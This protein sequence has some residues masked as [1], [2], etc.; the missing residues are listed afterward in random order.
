MAINDVI[1]KVAGQTFTGWKSVQVDRAIDALV[2]S[3]RLTLSDR[4]P[5]APD[6]WGIRAGDACEVLLGGETI[7]TA[8]IDRAAFS[9]RP[10]R[11]PIVMSGMEKTIDLTDCSAIHTPG[12]WKGRRLEQIA[13]DLTAPFGIKVKALV[14]TGAVFPAFALQQGESVFEAISRMARQRGVLPVTNVDG[15]LELIRPGQARAGFTLAYGENLEEIAFEDDYGDRFSDYILK[16]YARDGAS[17]PKAT[18]K[19]AGVTRYRPLLIVHDDDSTPGNL[20]DRAKH[21]AT[22][23]AGRGQR[24]QATVTGWRDAGGELYR[25][26]RLAA[27]RAAVVGVE[28]ERLIHAVSYRADDR[29]R[30]T[31][32]SLAPKEA[33]SLQAIPA[34][35][36]R[37]RSR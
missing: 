35:P 25:P 14:S 20:A 9:I 19:D 34:A 7:M 32:L 11:H 21:E 12:S 29:G 2:G 17:R 6:S 26:D 24:T 37:R 27:V 16:G 28:G 30:R 33:F 1:L 15:D 8:W 3:F 18:A 36:A 22:I 31:V 5:G 23:R 10:D 4:W 13:A